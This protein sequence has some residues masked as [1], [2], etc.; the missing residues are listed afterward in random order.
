M[1]G[2]ANRIEF[3]SCYYLSTTAKKGAGSGSENGINKLDNIVD[4]P[5][6]FSIINSENAFKEDTNKINN[7][8]PILVWE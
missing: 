7:G 6:L 5:S 3:N 4:F 2:S 8:Y 1:N